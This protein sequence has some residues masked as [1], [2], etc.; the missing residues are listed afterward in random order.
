MEEPGIIVTSLHN[1]SKTFNIKVNI[2]SKSLAMI[3][4]LKTL[5]KNA[6][7]AN[8]KIGPERGMRIIFN[9]MEAGE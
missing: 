4:V 2:T 6:S 5:N 8:S 7:E 9:K 1:V 3:C